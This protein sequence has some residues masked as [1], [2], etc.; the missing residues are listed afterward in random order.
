MAKSIVTL[1]K[2]GFHLESCQK[3][4]VG[5][6]ASRLHI[7]LYKRVRCTDTYGIVDVFVCQRLCFALAA[8]SGRKMRRTQLAPREDDIIMNATTSSIQREIL[9]EKEKLNNELL[10]QLEISVICEEIMAHSVARMTSI[11]EK[12]ASHLD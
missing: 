3:N 10:K 8:D 11:T 2:N 6:A 9:E 1:V 12:L 4:W 7:F 5:E